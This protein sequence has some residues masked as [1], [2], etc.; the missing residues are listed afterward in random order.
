MPFRQS[1]STC[2]L[3]LLLLCGATEASAYTD[4]GSGAM[5]FQIL[6]GGVIG[7]LFYFRRAVIR[8]SRQPGKNAEKGFAGSEN[9][10]R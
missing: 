9:P 10:G 1:C 2:L 8:V 6:I 5:L 7:C 3:V 4:P